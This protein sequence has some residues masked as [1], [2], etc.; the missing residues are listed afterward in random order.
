M[1]VM[2]MLPTNRTAGVK[3]SG[4]EVMFMLPRNR[5][6]G[7]KISGK[8]LLIWHNSAGKHRHIYA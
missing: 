6:A 3:I 4:S 7:V 1:A 8:K 5:T 2:F